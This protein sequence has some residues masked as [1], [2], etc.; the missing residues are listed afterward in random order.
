MSNES[1]SGLG[2]LA[3]QVG[4][5]ASGHGARLLTASLIIPLYAVYLPP[6]ELGRLALIQVAWSLMQN[7]VSLGTYTGYFRLVA[8]LRGGRRDAEADEATYTAF[9]A[10]SS[11]YLVTAVVIAGMA[12]GLRAAGLLEDWTLLLILA[13]FMPIASTP[14]EIAEVELRSSGR[15]RAWSGVA[16]LQQIGGT[17]GAAAAI[18]LGHATAEGILL[19]QF[20]GLS[21]VSLVSFPFFWRALAARPWSTAAL[22]QM[23]RFGAPTTPALLSAW[24]TQF[25]DRF[26]LGLLST[27]EQV[28]LY[29][30]GWR[31][32]QV[33]ETVVSAATM[34][35]WDP[36]LFRRYSEPGGDRLIARTATYLAL[37]GMA[38]VVPIGAVAYPL[39]DLLG[40]EAYLPV[41]GIVFF[42]ALSYW[43]GLLR[44]LLLAP[45]ATHMRPERAIPVW[46]A[47]AVVNVLLNLALI[48]PYGF[49]GA[50][51]ATVAS[52]AL[53][54]PL[55]VWVSRAIWAIPFEWSRLGA[56]TA[57][58]VSAGVVASALRVDVPPVVGI[59]AQPTLGVVLFLALLVALRFPRRDEWAVLRAV[60]R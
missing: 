38:I 25:A 32:G 29:S 30:L 31:V 27:I 45:T 19:A 48:P 36:F 47:T 60:A 56:V 23:V 49:K 33:A 55:A 2:E 37:G 41:A 42:V 20:A 28:G 44:H 15:A 43:I 10:L 16:L 14:R 53:S 8:E 51:A 1:P 46:V 58:G 26:L 50:I 18:A 5:Y 21:A 54:V 40:A 17:G 6:A 57:A 35:A 39:F 22:R 4:W 11:I 13:G 34:S 12:L 24:V 9:A 3:R 7:L 52:Y 59:V